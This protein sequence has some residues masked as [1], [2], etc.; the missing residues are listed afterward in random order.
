VQISPCDRDWVEVSLAG[1]WLATD[2]DQDT[3]VF[4]A[5]LRPGLE[6]QLYALWQ[7]AQAMTH[8]SAW[9]VF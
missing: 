3:G 9:A 7:S 4:M 1:T 8:H 6:Q 5:E 2:I